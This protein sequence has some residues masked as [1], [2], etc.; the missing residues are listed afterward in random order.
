MAACSSCRAPIYWAMTTGGKSMP[1][2][3]DDQGGYVAPK[4]VPDGNVVG[5]GRSVPAKFGGTCLEVRVQERGLLPDQAGTRRYRTHWE[6]CPYADE[7]RRK[8]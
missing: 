2:D 1:L 8:R 6:T 4:L 5:T 3:A 7:H